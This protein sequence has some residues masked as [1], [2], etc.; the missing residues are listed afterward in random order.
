MPVL[1]ATNQPTTLNCPT[2]AGSFPR[3]VLLC[4]SFRRGHYSQN[5]SIPTLLIS[6]SISLGYKYNNSIGQNYAFDP[7]PTKARSNCSNHRNLLGLWSLFRFALTDLS[8]M[9]AYRR[10]RRLARRLLSAIIFS[11][12]IP[13][14][15]RKRVLGLSRDYTVK[16]ICTIFT[17]VVRKSKN[18]DFWPS[19]PISH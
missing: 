10:R 5:W 1:L 18:D 15:M 14:S 12:T 2:N 17:P 3:A 6:Y 7:S 13:Y 4:R 9:R 11:T 19:E 8:G 16:N